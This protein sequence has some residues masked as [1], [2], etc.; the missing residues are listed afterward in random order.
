M[1][2]SWKC[3]KGAMSKVNF[4]DNSFLIKIII[5]C[6]LE[7]AS[8]FGKMKK[9]L[10]FFDNEVCH[11]DSFFCIILFFLSLLFFGCFLFRMIQVKQKVNLQ[12]RIQVYFHFIFMIYF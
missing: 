9:M 2:D 12:T 6:I 7:K 3:W 11:F 10:K 4:F 5:N 8:N 1:K